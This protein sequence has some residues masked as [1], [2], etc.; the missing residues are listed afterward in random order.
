VVSRSKKHPCYA[1]LITTHIFY[2]KA[3]MYGSNLFTGWIYREFGAKQVAP[4]QPPS[5]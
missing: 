1:E 3:M 2:H 4:R 5:R